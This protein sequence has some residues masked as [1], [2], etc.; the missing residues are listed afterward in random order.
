MTPQGGQIN[1]TALIDVGLGYVVVVNLQGGT[2][3]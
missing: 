2:H 1:T 3:I